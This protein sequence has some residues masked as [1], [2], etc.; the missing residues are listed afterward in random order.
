MNFRVYPNF[1]ILKKGNQ[2]ITIEA[3][4]KKMGFITELII[5][6]LHLTN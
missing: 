4:I 2:K 3:G 6:I 1:P 5:I